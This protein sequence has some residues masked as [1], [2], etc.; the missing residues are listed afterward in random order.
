MKSTNGPLRIGIGVLSDFL[1]VEFVK[2]L[3][4]IFALVQNNF[5]TDPGLKPIEDQKLE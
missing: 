2:C 4:E 1:G 3:A 5:P